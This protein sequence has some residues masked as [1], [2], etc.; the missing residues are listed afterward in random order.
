LALCWGSQRRSNS[1]HRVTSAKPWARRTSLNR[2][3][4]SW[5]NRDKGGWGMSIGLRGRWWRSSWGCALDIPLSI[6]YANPS[7]TIGKNNIC[8]SNGC[9][10]RD[11]GGWDG[12]RW[13]RGVMSMWGNT[14]SQSSLGIW[15]RRVRLA[16][17]I[18]TLG[19]PQHRWFFL[20]LGHELIMPRDY[21]KSQWERREQEM[22]RCTLSSLNRLYGGSCR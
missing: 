11:R 5:F 20:R 10:W 21:E 7:F 1:N 13:T 15:W 17:I 2:G 18:I 19:K 22:K 16:G 8:K 12:P 3:T 6:R 9:S 14:S 4:T